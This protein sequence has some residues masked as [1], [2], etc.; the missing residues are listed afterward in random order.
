MR[1]SR[2]KFLPI[3]LAFFWCVVA[4]AQ[5]NKSDFWKVNLTEPQEVT[6]SVGDMILVKSRTFPF[7]PA[8]LKKT[9]EVKYDHA[10][11]RLIE[12]EPPE[13]EGSMGKRYY[14]LTLSPG[15]SEVTVQINDQGQVV[16]AVTLKVTC[17]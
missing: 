11:L 16:E 10:H 14:F 9:F 12:E 5:V 15:P 7:V 3:L 17:R 8:N 6:A 2:V 1:V 4:K 13:G